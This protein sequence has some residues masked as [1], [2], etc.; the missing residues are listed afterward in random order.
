MSNFNGCI[1]LTIMHRRIIFGK[2]TYES[3]MA[4]SN[5]EYPASN[6]LVSC[7]V[8]NMTQ[9][10]QLILAEANRVIKQLWG[11]LTL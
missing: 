1:K 6:N 3:K 8:R 9:A 7:N 11:V 4:K 5:R 2:D 10:V